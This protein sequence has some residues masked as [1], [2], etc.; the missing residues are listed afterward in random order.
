MRPSALVW[1]LVLSHAAAQS[2]KTVYVAN[3]PE[4][5]KAMEDPDVGRI[6]LSKSISLNGSPLPTIDGRLLEIEAGPRCQEPCALDAQGQSR[7]FNVGG[8][9][10]GLILAHLTLRNAVGAG[11][12]SAVYVA[13]GVGAGSGTLS[14]NTCVFANNSA[15]GDGGAIWGGL[16]AI[17]SFA[18]CKL[19]GNRAENGGALAGYG[20]E[21]GITD[22]QILHN[23][24]RSAGG[25]LFFEGGN[26]T[27]SLSTSELRE[28]SAG[29]NGGGALSL[30]ATTTNRTLYDL[31]TSNAG[32]HSVTFANNTSLGPG[33]A[34]HTGPFGNAAMNDV[35]IIGN[36]AVGLGGGLAADA[37]NPFA[38]TNSSFS[39]NVVSDGGG[40]AIAFGSDPSGHAPSSPAASVV[41]N[42]TVSHNA[43]VTATPE[44]FFRT[45]GA[46]TI[47]HGAGILLLE[48][49]LLF[50]ASHFDANINHGL[51]RDSQAP[52]QEE[53]VCTFG[54][55]TVALFKP[56]EK[57]AACSSCGGTG[58]CV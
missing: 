11:N 43:I 46:S 5:V 51:S 53:D 37:P 55:S 32:V 44:P 9:P 25:G 6:F 38:I 7:I 34:I 58:S 42:V 22:S 24:A 23:K 4:L 21:V 1:F 54:A 16:H 30:G 18:G 36:V 45:K 50:T 10:G 29:I 49:Q 41:N 48:G 47:T 19:S 8:T 26:A 20:I 39:S 2:L 14:I 40:A 13:P 57:P 15:T 28:N 31:G 35:H 3:L 33:G 27:L 52:G 56:H 12:G 17:M